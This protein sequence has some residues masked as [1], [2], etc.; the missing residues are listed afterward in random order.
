MLDALV[1]LLNIRFWQY[2]CDL[3][4]SEGGPGPLLF[5]GADGTDLPAMHPSGH[6][7][8]VV[9]GIFKPAF[10]GECVGGRAGH[11]HRPRRRPLTTTTEHLIQRMI[12]R[13]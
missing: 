6:P 5:P 7:A 2:F 3:S 1:V 11:S 13:S 9:S 4:V 8:A 12:D 10:S